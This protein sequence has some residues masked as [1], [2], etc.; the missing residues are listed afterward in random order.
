M[1]KRK[2]LFIWTVYE[3]PK[4]YPNDFV[5]RIFNFDKPTN[6]VHTAKTLEEVRRFIPEGLYRLE[7]LPQDDP[8]IVEVW[9]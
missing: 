2:E 7:R 1:E 6:V 5:V 8:C 9:L 4:D 3:K